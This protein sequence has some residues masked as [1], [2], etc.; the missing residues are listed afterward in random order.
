MRSPST[1]DRAD[2]ADRADHADR[3][4]R[5]DRA[6]VLPRA[7]AAAFASNPHAACRWLHAAHPALAGMSPTAVAW[8]SA[9]LAGYARRLLL[10]DTVAATAARESQAK[11]GVTGPAT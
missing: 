5:A 4:D 3:A 8:A 7:A 11:S 6:R 1:A 9:W 10:L 2:R